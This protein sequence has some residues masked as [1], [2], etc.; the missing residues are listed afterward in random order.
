MSRLLALLHRWFRRPAPTAPGALITWGMATYKGHR[1]L[2]LYAGK[3]RYGL[4]AKLQT[5]DGKYTFWVDVAALSDVHPERVCVECGLIDAGMPAAPL[6][7]PTRYGAL[8]GP[9][10]ARLDALTCDTTGPQ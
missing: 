1:Y 2:L 8:C 6:V 4:R 7:R 5:P 9:C 3:T 10:Q